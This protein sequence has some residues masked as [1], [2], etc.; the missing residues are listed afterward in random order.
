[1]AELKYT[2]DGL[3]FW[4][5]PDFSWVD[6]GNV[7]LP[8]LK[9]AVPSWVEQAPP[10][11][12][13]PDTTPFEV[14]AQRVKS[15]VQGVKQP[16]QD[17]RGSITGF[18]GPKDA[19]KPSYIMEPDLLESQQGQ[20]YPKGLM[21]RDDGS[22]YYV[23]EPDKTVPLVK[24]PDIL[25]IASTPEGYKF[26]MPKMLDIGGNVMGNVGGK[27]GG[28]VMAKPGEMVLGSGVV[29]KQLNKDAELLIRGKNAEIG[30]ETL[31]KL[32]KPNHFYRAMTHDEYEATIGAGK[33][34]K[35]NQ[36]FSVRNEGTSFAEDLPTA[37]SYA[38]FGRTDPR[39]TGKPTY[40][41]EINGEDGLVR[42]KDG[43]LK[44]AD[45]ISKDRITNIIKMENKDGSI[46]GKVLKSDTRNQVGSQVG[47]ALE[48]PRPNEQGFYSTLEHAIS[49]SKVQKADAQ[50]WTNYLRN[51]PGVKAEELELRLKDL[52]PGQL[53]KD[54]IKEIVDKNKVELKEEVLGGK[55]DLPEISNEQILA[56]AIKIANER[57]TKFSRIPRGQRRDELLQEARERLEVRQIE[58]ANKLGN[59][60][61]TRYHQYQLPG[62]E[63]YR[64]MLVKLP[65]VTSPKAQEALELTK[66]MNAGEFNSLNDIERKALFKKRDDLLKAA[67]AEEG[68]TFQAPH[69]DDKGTNLL[70]HVRMND[71]SVD[72]NKSLH[73]EEIQSD[74]MQ[75]GRDYGFKGEKA[76][77]EPQFNKIEQKIIDSGDEAIM[78][79]PDL[80]EILK[81]AVDKKL[82]TKEEASLYER[83]VKTEA[84]EKSG[85]QPPD[86][87]F[88]KG[89]EELALKRMLKKAVDEG[90]D[91]ISWTPGEA[92]AL[93][94][95][96]EI[97]QK[98]NSVEWHN[99]KMGKP[100]DERQILIT[101]ASGSEIELTVDK[102]GRI[103]GGYKE[104]KGK[105][106]DEVLGKDFAK[107][108]MD[109]AEGNIDAK[110]YV[111]GAEGFKQAYDKRA[112]DIMNNLTKKYGGKVESKELPNP[113]KF[114]VHKTENKY[115]NH[116]YDVRSSVT[117][118]NKSS[119]NVHAAFNN[120][121]EAEA[122]MKE[123]QKGDQIHFLKITPELRAKVQD[124]GFSLFANT[125]VTVPIDYNPFER[126]KQDKKY[127]LVPVKENPFQ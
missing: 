124:E 16:V 88:K 100:S 112:V 42:T 118:D 78:G 19:A 31:Q 70:Y 97:R 102:S 47:R 66:R 56:E 26:A 68:E 55:T 41:V 34:I 29:G 113:R 2:A 59:T 111:M 40:L 117:G 125:P 95:Q 98:I 6:Q 101:P 69:F 82:I 65:I 64:E 51:Q 122:K 15:A 94:Y 25:P 48:R 93:R 3:P 92:Q 30:E 74:W 116:V 120:S 52:P 20:E 18:F 75:R 17:D 58:E 73:L 14:A 85:Q 22:F 54:Q 86:A 60:T 13:N 114:F 45:E 35:S 110:G 61:Y 96:N 49:N 9:P 123:L 84:G 46:I 50:G 27:L 79:N 10:I 53:T 63:N 67:K 119:A 24:R 1:M 80:K 11:L 90:Y 44:A 33:G 126:D 99:K 5:N 8:P 62:G 109:K 107:Q 4:D 115:G 83:Y 104:L 77:L 39:K 43:Y 89:W 108:I 37:E 127:K 105:T 121:A 81:M 91:A 32:S 103:I 28:A 36:K 106:L 87:P 21:Q 71:R 12:R 38:N 57:G 76:K 72:G 23:G 7:P